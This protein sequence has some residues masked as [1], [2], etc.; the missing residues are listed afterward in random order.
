MFGISF[1]LSLFLVCPAVCSLLIRMFIYCKYKV[2][3]VLH[4][5][6]QCPVFTLSS[7]VAASTDLYSFH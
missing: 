2:L 5:L 3:L 6:Y 7:H 1:I 4:Y